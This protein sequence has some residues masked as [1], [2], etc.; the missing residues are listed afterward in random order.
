MA[1]YCEHCETSDLNLRAMKQFGDM[2]S[3]FLF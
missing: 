1:G 3:S 2:D